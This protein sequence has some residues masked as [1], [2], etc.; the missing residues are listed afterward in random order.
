MKLAVVVGQ[1]VATVKCGGFEHGR[2]LLVDLID[3]KGKQKGEVSVAADDIGAGNGEW[4]LIVEG[5]SAR[6]TTGLDAPV[7]M[8][9]IG[10]VDEVVLNNKVVYHK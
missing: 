1:L 7:D 4:V 9:V 3:T 6:K 2:L 5:S 10:I 8:S